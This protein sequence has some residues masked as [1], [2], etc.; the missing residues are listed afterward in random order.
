MVDA[1][2]LPNDP[3]MSIARGLFGVVREGPLVQNT[4]VRRRRHRCRGSTAGY[5][6]RGEPRV[7]VRM[8]LVKGAAT[9]LAF[10]TLLLLSPVSSPDR[11]GAQEAP[12]GA[13][14]LNA[15]SW[16][17]IDA[18]TGLYLAGKDPDKQVPIASTTKLMVALV[19]LDEG[20]DLDEQVTV[21]E[22]AASYAGSIY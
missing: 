11:A 22:D 13:P 16:T 2:N 3:T 19:A 10:L 17:L 21:S 5:R 6:G 15:G 4:L 12:P 20:V 14:K 9:F 8:N 7:R 18:D 1:V